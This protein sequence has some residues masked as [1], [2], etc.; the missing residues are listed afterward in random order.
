[1]NSTVKKVA[2]RNKS[3]EFDRN[4]LCNSL[5]DS[6]LYSHLKVFLEPLY[7]P[8]H[9]LWLGEECR[10]MVTHGLRH[11]LNV[12]RYATRLYYDTVYN[13]K[14]P[15]RNKDFLKEDVDKVCLIISIWLHD[16]G[17]AGPEIP[18]Y[19]YSLPRE[20]RIKKFLEI[21]NE[22]LQAAGNKLGKRINTVEDLDSI[23]CRWI[24][25]N[26]SL[27]SYFNIT[28]ANQ[29]IR[30]DILG[31]KLENVFKPKRLLSKRD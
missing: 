28:K 16:W 29:S 19:L 25:P 23:D 21:L 4:W 20:K 2:K 22:T 10:F 24:R 12:F 13:V 9:E 3:L 30:L 31:R 7:D 11:V 18:P 14:N 6:E 26:H 5:K 17:M 1:M 27:I 8:E 15:K